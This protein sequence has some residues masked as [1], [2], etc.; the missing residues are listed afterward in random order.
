M[1]Y[2]PR[3]PQL[4]FCLFVGQ[5]LFL[6]D[7]C[8]IANFVIVG[9]S[10]YL[11][12]DWVTPVRAPQNRARSLLRPTTHH[13]LLTAGELWQRPFTCPL[14]RA[15]S[16]SL[17][18]PRSSLFQSPSPSPSPSNPAFQLLLLS[19]RTHTRMD[20]RIKGLRN[21]RRMGAVLLH[22]DQHLRGGTARLVCCSN[23]EL[24]DIPRLCALL[25]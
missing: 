25:A 12:V 23:R 1:S 13:P 18:L 5:H 20:A 21:Q 8:W 24:D 11:L 2:F 9:A 4:L 6:L 15:L 14:S 19:S 22:A 7:F 17:S 3:L 10:I 16:L